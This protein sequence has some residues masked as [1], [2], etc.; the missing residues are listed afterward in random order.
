MFSVFRS[1]SQRIFQHHFI[2]SVVFLQF[3]SMIGTLAQAVGGVVIAR[4]LQPDAFGVY[5]LALG[6]A[7]VIGFLLG[8]GAQDAMSTIIGRA[9][10]E[11]NTDIILNAFGFLVKIAAITGVVA[12]VIS[13]VSPYVTYAL[14][15][16]RAIGLYAAV[17]VAASALSTILFT[18]TV[19]GLQVVGSIRTMTVLSALD[20]VLRFSLSV[21][22][23]W[24][25]LGIRGAILGQLFGAVALF[26]VSVMVWRRTAMRNSLMP[27]LTA[28]V[29]AARSVSIRTYLGF[30]AWVMLDRN[31]NI[32]FMSLP[33][34]LVGIYVIPAQVA[35]FKLAFGF[36]NLA[37]TLL[38][39]IST[40]LN[41]EFPRT[42][43]I[44]PSKLRSLF[45][46]VSTYGVAISFVLTAAAIII[47]PIAFRILYGESFLPSVKYVFGLI[48]YGALFGLGV[49][50]GPM[51][52]AL[53]RVR[54]SIMIN[55][56][57]LLI[58]IPL[59]IIM[60]RQWHL[61][62]AVVMVTLWYTTSQVVS[63]LYLASRLK[64]P[65]NKI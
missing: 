34:V 24:I 22:L 59:G 25:G 40:L 23:V 56:V 21:L 14:Y 61:W 60:V 47:S 6:V 44:E 31:I 13:L 11:R 36:V 12:L 46:K 53:G 49:G 45:L 30:T 52:R 20:Q 35:Y 18:A 39:P 33:V 55:T 26:A 42:Q 58:G 43:A 48:V 1:A 38:G 5:T 51:W 19:L 16:S 3:G 17:V 50:L 65:E 62:G 15:G 28:L 32:L 10:A 64:N 54:T 7:G 57:T 37:L 27:S 29:A 9:Y 8:T 41:V 63:F 2:R 4:L